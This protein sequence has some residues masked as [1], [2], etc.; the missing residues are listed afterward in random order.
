[1]K[2]ARFALGVTVGTLLLA[3]ACLSAGVIC[4]EG[5]IAGR[6]AGAHPGGS[7][8]PPGKEPSLTHTA[9]V[10]WTTKGDVDRTDV[11]VVTKGSRPSQ[12]DCTLFKDGKQKGC[13]AYGASIAPDSNFKV[14]FVRA[15]AEFKRAGW[16]VA[17]VDGS[18]SL[19]LKVHGWKLADYSNPPL[20]TVRYYAGGKLVGETAVVTAAVPEK[21]RKAAKAAGAE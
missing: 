10:F 1:M 4:G 8:F 3:G 12:S 7:P 20:V 14:C 21:I 16:R 18:G 5:P 17:K 6:P 11:E 15:A 9:K 13:G 2:D 19:V